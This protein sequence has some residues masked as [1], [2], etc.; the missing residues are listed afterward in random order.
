MFDN[1]LP[2]FTGACWKSKLDGNHFFCFG[3]SFPFIRF[4]N[5]YS[6]VIARNLRT[7]SLLI[8]EVW[9]IDETSLGW[10][11]THL[12]LSIFCCYVIC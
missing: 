7:Q 9:M 3:K 4:P 2:E 1:K 12:N 6:C 11:D 8:I 10:L 5:L